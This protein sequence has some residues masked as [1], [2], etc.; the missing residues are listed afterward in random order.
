MQS[1][2]Q[3]G[4]ALLDT[5]VLDYA[6]KA[7]TKLLASQLLERLVN[8][9]ELAISEYLRFEIYRGLKMSSIPSVKPLVDSF[10]AYTVDKATIDLAAALTTCYERDEATHKNRG[11]FSDGDILMAATAIINRLV[12]VT[13]NRADFPAPYFNELRKHTYTDA[14]GKP[15]VFYELK[16]DILYLNAMLEICYPTK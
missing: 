12:I 14:K 15:W 7:R 1:P 5:N 16:H 2:K 13:A 8:N 3:F 9:Y 10:N 6:F 11:G 4:V